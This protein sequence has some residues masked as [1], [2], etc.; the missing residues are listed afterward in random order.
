[1]RQQPVAITIEPVGARTQADLEVLLNDKELGFESAANPAL[2]AAA[3]SRRVNLVAAQNSLTE[4]VALL[5]KLLKDDPSN[6]NWQ[7]VL[8]D[9]QVR[10]ATLQSTL[11]A[12]VE[13]ETLARKGIAS[14]KELAIREQAPPMTLDEAAN[15]LLTV[16]PV[17]LRNPVLAV[18]FAERAV[19]LSQE[20]RPSLLLTLARAYRASGLMDKS[21]MI[22]SEGLA[23]LPPW[24]TGNAKPN[25]RKLLELQ[26]RE[27]R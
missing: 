12:P 9:A 26:M 1:M 8:A 22:A 19:A 17:S 6:Q 27:S 21:R 18:S 11:H 3:D 25:I 7:T 13:P 2:A 10:L 14:L 15:A 24:Q 23:L 16:E 4:E 5:D 20:K